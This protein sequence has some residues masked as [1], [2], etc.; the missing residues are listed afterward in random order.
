MGGAPE[1]A[2]VHDHGLVRERDE[3]D[4]EVVEDLQLRH[5]SDARAGRDRSRDGTVLIR[6]EDGVR[7]DGRLLELRLEFVVNDRVMY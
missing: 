3:L 4:V 5:D 6:L 1:Q 2:D 7:R